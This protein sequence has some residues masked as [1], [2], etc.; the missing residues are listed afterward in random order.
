MYERL[1]GGLFKNGLVL[2]GD[3]AYLNTSY[4]ATPFPNV[5]SDSKDDYIFFHSQV[6]IQVECTL[7]ILV[8]RWRILRSAIPCNIT[9][10]RTIAFSKLSGKV[11]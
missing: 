2:F 4:M 5:S 9:I 11:A 7:G 3:N 1:E 8:S 10:V 6:C